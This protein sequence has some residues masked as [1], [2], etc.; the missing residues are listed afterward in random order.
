MTANREQMNEKRNLLKCESCGKILLKLA[1]VM[2]GREKKI[3]PVL[4]LQ[5]KVKLLDSNICNISTHTK[6]IFACEQRLRKVNIRVF[7][8]NLSVSSLPYDQIYYINI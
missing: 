1:K 3:I 6:S 8:E 2:I 4:L 7:P 5:L